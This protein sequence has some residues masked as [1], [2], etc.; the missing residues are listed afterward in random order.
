MS[1][2]PPSRPKQSRQDSLDLLRQAGVLD[3]VSLLA[4]RGYYRDSMGKPGENDRAIYDDAIFVIAPDCYVAFNANTDPSLYRKGEGFGKD[5]GVATLD[6]GTW[7]FIPGLHRG[8]YIA[9]RQHG[10]FTVTRDGYKENYKDTGDGFGI[11][12]HRGGNTTTG[13]LGCQTIPPDQWEEFI[14][15]VLRKMNEC[16]QKTIRYRL[17]ER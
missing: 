6:P 14:G 2:K 16:G 9:L 1:I 3:Q 8:E 4:V 5:K 12:I 13:S 11:N 7:N 10:T 17:V 15:L